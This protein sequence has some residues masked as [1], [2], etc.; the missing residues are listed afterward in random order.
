V[1][2]GGD[3][4][5]P[6]GV[7]P[8]A[9][10]IVAPELTPEL[11]GTASADDGP[12]LPSAISDAELRDAIGAR[13]AFS[14]AAPPPP[15][16]PPPP[17]VTPVL[18]PPPAPSAAPARRRRERPRP[19]P[20]RE[21]DDADPAPP[22]SRRAMVLGLVTLILGLV[23]AAFVFL[24]RANH[25]RYLITCQ[26]DAIV[27]EQGRTFPPW[28][29]RPLD[30]TPWV[31][32]KIP[33]NAECKPRE[34][35]DDHELAGWY[36]DVLMDQASTRLT[37]AEVTK[38]DVD[39]A[40]VQLQQ[41]L[42]LARDPDRR[43][44]RRDIERLLGDV[45]YWRATDHVRTAAE[46]LADAAKQFEAAAT[47]RPRHVSDAGAWAAYARRLAD[48]L[49]LGPNGKPV[50]PAA[51]AAERPLAPAGVALP[52]EPSGNGSAAPLVTAPPDAGVPSGGVLL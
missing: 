23:I 12:L 1:S 39:A 22:R 24:G 40:D 49:H 3:D 37:R 35:G 38:P 29:S 15:Q 51:A 34:T 4:E 16:Q 7:A 13:P 41:A 19:A 47:A 10:V 6:P 2:E 31:P 27:A 11:A 21:D 50:A 17:S 36:L 5:R 45:Q 8:E 28:G 18:A 25:E 48:E 33:P 43:D 32:I 26:P 46:A 14:V 52:V 9:L 20:E 44:Q 30:G 42:L